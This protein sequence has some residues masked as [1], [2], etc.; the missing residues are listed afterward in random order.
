MEETRTRTKARGRIL[1]GHDGRRRFKAFALGRVADWV[2]TYRG[3]DGNLYGYDM[4]ILED[5]IQKFRVSDQSPVAHGT[6]G[7][8]VTISELHSTFRSLERDN[9]LPEL[10]ETFA[11]YVKDYRDV[12]I[13][14]EG[15]PID[16]AGA[17]ATTQRYPLK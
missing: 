16:P 13:S 4:A 15:A 14:L 9:A 17:I 3:A 12:L 1:H 6:T 8:E 10:A 2:V 11:L 7:V 5:S